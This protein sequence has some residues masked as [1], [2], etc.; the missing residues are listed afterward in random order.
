MPTSTILQC[1]C[2]QFPPFVR[3]LS[4]KNEM[5]SKVDGI[6]VEFIK[7]FMDKLNSWYV[8]INLVPENATNLYLTQD[9]DHL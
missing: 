9:R 4:F 3:V 5:T 6:L 2:F 7:A 8:K 1:I